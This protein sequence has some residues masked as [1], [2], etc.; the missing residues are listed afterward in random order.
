MAGGKETP[1]QR[2]IG[3][4]Y[5]VLLG[6]I[7]L[8]V[9]DSL[10]DA[11]K[12]ITNSLDAST[13]NVNTG[14]QNTYSAFEATKLKEQAERAKPIYDKAKQASA[15]AAELNTYVEQLKAKLI[16]EG[17]GINPE[18]DDVDARDNLDISPR[19]MINQKNGEK[20]KAKIDETRQRLMVALGKDS[21]G[22]QFSLNTVAPKPHG[23]VRKSWQEANFGD[24]IPLGA[25]LTTL[26]KIEA[27]SKNAENEVVKKLLGKIDQ[28]QVTLDKFS[29]VVVAPS[30]YVIAGQPYTAQIFL[31]AYDSKSN[32]DITVNGS[33]VSVTD[34]K[35]NYTITAS[36]EGKHTIEGVITVKNNTTGKNDPYPFKQE[37]TVA[38][39]SA[40]IS[41]DKMNVLYIG[42]P[43]PISVSAPGVAASDL[44]VHFSG[45][46]SL[47]G[48]GGHYTAIVNSIGK[49]T[50][51]VS[52]AKGAVLGS[53]EFRIKRIPD[54]KPQFAGKSGGN[55]SSANIRAQDRLFAQLDNFDFDAKFN[56]TH[57]TMLV[58]KP[59]QDAIILS[60]SGGELT[61]AMHS[62]LNTVTPGTTVIFKDIVAVG[63]DH[64]PRSLDPIVLSAN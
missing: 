39:P 9:P 27:D 5:L 48:S 60:G 15:I 44:N 55:T 25:A 35:G 20:L 29:A 2:M 1:R 54:P 23:D 22:V 4:L 10:L 33:K 11:F 41:P 38:R 7:A 64:S 3:I 6:L 31:T 49:A 36:G 12:N 32:P 63:P 52:G 14:L 24:G 28:A 18:I 13:R 58:V 62:A 34:G 46:G 59:R 61:G 21:V 8:N 50:I 16:Q 43:N 56:V 19:I 37:Y 45:A 53:T 17:G 51:S 26:A 30:S 47:S 40:V 57:F 42:V